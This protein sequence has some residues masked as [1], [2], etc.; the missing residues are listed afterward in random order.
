[1][2]DT[3]LLVGLC[4]SLLISSL[5]ISLVTGTG[6][7]SLGDIAGI[8]TQN[9]DFETD[10]H[11]WKNDILT[12]GSDWKIIDGALISQGAGNNRFYLQ[13]GGK[14]DG[15]HTATYHIESGGRTYAII[16]RDT[17]YFGDSIQMRVV[18]AGVYLESYALLGY[19]PFQKFVPA[20]IPN[21]AVITVSLDESTSRVTVTEIGRAHV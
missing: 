13:T 16:V 2:A 12:V 17:N 14:P 1:M 21:T 4:L 15:M 7:A 19:R 8:V 18:P 11:G 6:A 9:I 5:A 20:T 3:R 10:T